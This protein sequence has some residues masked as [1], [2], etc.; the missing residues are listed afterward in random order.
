MTQRKY[1][2]GELRELKDYGTLGFEK[3]C[4]QC[5]LILAPL[6]PKRYNKDHPVLGKFNKVQCPACGLK[7][8]IDYWRGTWEWDGKEGLE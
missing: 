2:G 1:W 5:E 3:L 6:N 4:P 8:P 7:I